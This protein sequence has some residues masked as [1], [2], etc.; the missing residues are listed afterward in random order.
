MWY[1]L[2]LNDLIELH[3]G[4]NPGSLTSYKTFQQDPGLSMQ[5]TLPGLY[6]SLLRTT[7]PP[8]LIAHHHFLGRFYH[9]LLGQNESAVFTATHK[10][11]H[12]SAAEN[13]WR[14]ETSRAPF[15]PR[16]TMVGLVLNPKSR[17]TPRILCCF[18]VFEWKQERKK[19]RQKGK[20]T[21]QSQFSLFWKVLRSR[22]RREQQQWVMKLQ[23]GST[24]GRI[25][26][27]CSQ[28]D[29]EACLRPQ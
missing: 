9:L 23:L 10:D 11:T 25:S 29:K 14:R 1:W 27:E 15:T 5:V 8:A 17:E 12:C 18:S 26:P 16:P 21:A 13:C 28:S 4:E 19:E 2:K 7:A 6:T 3:C 22:F 20:K 24:V